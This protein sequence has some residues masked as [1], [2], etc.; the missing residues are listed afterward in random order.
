MF[1]RKEKLREEYDMKLVE[2]M[3]KLK[4]DWEQQRHLVQISFEYSDELLYHEKISKIKYF[5]LFKEAKKRK[6]SLD[7]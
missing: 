7:R 3:E 5:Y 1:N 4:E 6:I 2:L